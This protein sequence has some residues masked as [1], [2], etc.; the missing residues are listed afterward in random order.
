VIASGGTYFAYA[1]GPWAELMA[2]GGSG[3]SSL[4]RSSWEAVIVVGLSVGLIIAFR[5]LFDRSNRL[6]RTMAAASFGA[7]ILHPAMVVGL[8]AYITDV[9]LSA[10]AKFALVSVL[11]TA[12]AF[13]IA[14]MAG[15]VPGI[16][17]VLGASPGA[18]R[19]RSPNEITLLGQ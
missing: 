17:A 16:R 13:A 8:Q 3:L 11:G 7:Y 4:I 9:R 19:R 5:E 2:P 6:L 10:F 15:Q 18:R 14:H 1:F 12:A